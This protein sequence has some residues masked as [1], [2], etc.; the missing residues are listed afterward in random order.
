MQGFVRG[1]VWL[2]VIGGALGVLA[3]LFFVEAWRV[4]Q[5][6][7]QFPASIQPT[8]AVEDLLL[9]RR[10]SHPGFGELARC[11]SP[12]DGSFVIGRVF[13]EPGDH[14]D[15]TDDVITT[16]NKP[17]GSRHGCPT[18][19]LPHPVS[20]NLVKMSCN[21]AET[22]AWSFQFLTS[23]DRAVSAHSGATVEAGKLYLVSDNRL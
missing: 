12:Q 20:Q 13:G 21:V 6:D 15:I 3:H 19:M 11:V 4:P 7:L 1:L 10:N 14:V 9:V 5:G 17:F 8:L 16:N 23:P 18:V 22:G 2:A